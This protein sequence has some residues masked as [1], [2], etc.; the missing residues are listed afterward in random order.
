MAFQ[1]ATQLSK[2]NCCL[3]VNA[4]Q[5]VPIMTFKELQSKV[6]EDNAGCVVLDVRNPEQYEQ[7]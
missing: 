2:E 6:K 7:G 1:G 3:T 4:M 5:I